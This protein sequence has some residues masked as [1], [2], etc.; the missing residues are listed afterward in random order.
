M[1]KRHT[2]TTTTTQTPMPIQQSTT[3]KEK[4]GPTAKPKPPLTD[5]ERE[6]L[7]RPR[8]LI[9]GAGIGGLVLGNLLLKGGIRVDI[10]ERANEVKPLGSAI[11]LGANIKAVFTQLGIYDELVAM[12]KEY[13][14]VHIYNGDAEFQFTT[15]FSQQIDAGGS[16]EYIVPRPQLYDLLLRQIPKDRIHMSKKITSMVQGRNGV[17]IRAADGTTYEGDILVGADGAHSAVRQCLY[18]LLEK[19]K[20]GLLP[21]SDTIVPL[22]FRCVCLVGQTNVLD[23][24][25][26]LD[27]KNSD[28]KFY[29]VHG[30]TNYVWVTLTTQANTICFMVVQFLDKNSIKYNDSFRNSEWGPEA[31]EAMANQTRDFKVPGSRA[32][33]SNNKRT[34]TTLTMGDYYDRTSKD[35][36][37]KVMLEEKVFKTWY[38]GRTVLIGDGKEKKRKKKKKTLL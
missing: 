8:V 21:S 7:K 25:E 27:L 30:D 6:Q 32:S 19:D 23:P 17:L 11:A 1:S 5:K 34:T 31:A 33:G 9:V 24:E 36:M 3:A 16:P 12:G 4:F 14:T 20:K 29:A 2:P 13:D 35:L 26:F 28:A 18:Q 38:G 37:S 15:D 10:F 22:P